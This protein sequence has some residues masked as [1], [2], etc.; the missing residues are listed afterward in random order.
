MEAVGNPVA[1]R[2]DGRFVRNPTPVWFNSSAIEFLV[3][4]FVLHVGCDGP[5]RDTR[6][7]CY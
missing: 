3:V 6:S 4:I 2:P 1:E 7:G 5:R